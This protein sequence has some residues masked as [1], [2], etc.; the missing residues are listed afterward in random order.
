MM[1]ARIDPQLTAAESLSRPARWQRGDGGE[2]ECA[3][4]K[5]AMI[6]QVNTPWPASAPPAPA[7]TSLQLQPGLTRH[8]CGGGVAEVRQWPQEDLGWM[9]GKT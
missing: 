1:T 6:C 3:A 5:D 9:G 4:R 7:S 2:G 8:L